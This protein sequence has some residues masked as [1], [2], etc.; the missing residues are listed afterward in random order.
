M[1]PNRCGKIQRLQQGEHSMLEDQLFA[2]VSGGGVVRVRAGMG[3]R[4]T[5]TAAACC[6]FSGA[7]LLA[8]GGWKEK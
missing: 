3:F 2:E 5:W 7:S 6:R 8:R 4:K 1:K